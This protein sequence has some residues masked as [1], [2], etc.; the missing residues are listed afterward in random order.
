MMCN[1][2]NKNSSLLQSNFD[3]K[4]VLKKIIGLMVAYI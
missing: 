4:I 1:V 2:K 3:M